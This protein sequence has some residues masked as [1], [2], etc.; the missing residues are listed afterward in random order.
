MLGSRLLGTS[1][2][3]LTSN[4]SNMQSSDHIVGTGVWC[5]P[6]SDFQQQKDCWYH[7]ICLIKHAYFMLGGY[8]E[9]LWFKLK[10]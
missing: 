5:P 1:I 9:I 3:H 2:S 10:V 6:T 4:I 8:K 7:T